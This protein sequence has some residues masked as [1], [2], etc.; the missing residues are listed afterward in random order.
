MTS[1]NR[2]AYPKFKQFP[3]AKEL[4]ELYTPTPEEIK[5]VKSKTKSHNGFLSFMVMLK[6][7]QRLGYFPHPELIPIAVIKHLRSCLKLQDWIK[8]IP[9]ERQR[10]TYQN[11]IR[12]YLGVK[13]YDKA[14][15]KIIA[16]LVAKQAEVLDHPADLINV[17]IE[18]LVKERYELPAF[19]TLD[20][21]IGHIRTMVNNRLF[22]RVSSV[23]GITEILY[24]DQLL[25]RDIEESL[26]TLNLLKSPPKSATLGG[27]KQLLAK[28][29]ALMTFGNA[30]QLLSTI[31]PTKVRYFA[32][33]AR[34]LDISEFRDINIPKRRTL[35]ICL[36]YSAQVKTR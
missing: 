8:T 19:S 35:L 26:Y 30:K 31:A 15:Q 18:E 21:L 23:L 33:Q 20:R 14:A 4:A 12:L 6:S 25:L 7:F 27:M 29:D 3:D 9:S 28:F 10:Y 16:I 36:L 11:A 17:A 24:L 32:A 1:I 5:F 22:Q 2:T 13:Q 34:A